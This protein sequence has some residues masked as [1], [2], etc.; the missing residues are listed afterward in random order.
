MQEQDELA[1]AAILV[2]GVEPTKTDNSELASE[3]MFPQL[4]N[5]NDMITGS[6]ASNS[7]HVVPCMPAIVVPAVRKSRMNCS[8]TGKFS[9]MSFLQTLQ[10][11]DATKSSLPIVPVNAKTCSSKTNYVLHTAVTLPQATTFRSLPDSVLHKLQTSTKPFKGQVMNVY[12]G[13]LMLKTPK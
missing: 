4:C 10:F 11:H 12:A 5:S 7:E 1:N 6:I 2:L 3:D 9:V 13:Q 8:D